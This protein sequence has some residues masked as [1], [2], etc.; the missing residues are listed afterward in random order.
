M[1]QNA[2]DVEKD[3]ENGGTYLY[4]GVLLGR[5]HITFRGFRN[6]PDLYCSRLQS[7]ALRS[8]PARL[9]H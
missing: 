7:R 3:F 2:I 6:G 8:V 5:W 9:V 1:N 4:G